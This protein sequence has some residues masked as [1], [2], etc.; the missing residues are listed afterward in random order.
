MSE[1]LLAAVVFSVP[2]AIWAYFTYKII[3]LV[4]TVL[5]VKQGMT[6]KKVSELIDGPE[7]SEREVTVRVG[8]AKDENTPDDLSPKGLANLR[9]LQNPLKAVDDMMNKSI[10]KAHS[11]DLDGEEV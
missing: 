2:M 3:K 9:D 6:E 7:N 8:K 4:V 5:L 10:Q 1:L 11:P